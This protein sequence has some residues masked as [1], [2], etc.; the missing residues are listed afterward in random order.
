MPYHHA[1]AFRT[2]APVSVPALNLLQNTLEDL[3]RR[4]AENWRVMRYSLV[5]V[6][7]E[8]SSN[9]TAAQVSAALG[10]DV[11][12]Q[13]SPNVDLCIAP[14]TEAALFERLPQL[15]S[16]LYIVSN[17]E[18]R[19]GTP[20]AAVSAGTKYRV[21]MHR[22]NA[23]RG[24]TWPLGCCG[25]P[26]VWQF[27]R[28]PTLTA[29]NYSRFDAVWLIE[30]DTMVYGA[31]SL[32]QL[33]ARIDASAPAA[34]AAFL[35]VRYRGGDPARPDDRCPGFV[36]ALHT[37]SFEAVLQ[38]MRRD[39]VPHVCFSA[40]FQRLSVAFADAYLREVQRFATSWDETM[41]QP[42]AWHNQLRV[43]EIEPRLLHPPMP[44]HLELTGAKYS[45]REVSHLMRQ[46]TQNESSADVV[47]VWH[48]EY[49]KRGAS[50]AMP[51]LNRAY[52]LT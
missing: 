32:V 16:Q 36:E 3:R 34:H 19:A 18:T 23:A 45:R 30:D 51:V 24:A 31:L 25:R 41:P 37:S 8:T 42:L 11:H 28:E 15:L 29:F 39:A 46:L 40:A 21:S 20:W 14:F 9:S 50:R 44:M 4:N 27:S 5:V 2:M 22:T 52:T 12:R 33:L 17:S 49:G 26:P 10:V 43:V 13:C 47:G 38:R 48:V 35:G 7:D 6:A 1:I